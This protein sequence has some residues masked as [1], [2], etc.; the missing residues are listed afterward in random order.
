MDFS[1]F[2]VRYHR[3]L[4][5][6]VATLF[7]FSSL[8][9]SILFFNNILVNLNNLSIIDCVEYS[10]ILNFANFCGNLAIGV[11]YW[12]RL[13]RTNTYVGEKSLLFW[14]GRKQKINMFSTPRL[15]PNKLLQ[16]VRYN[17]Q[18]TQLVLISPY[19]K[20]FW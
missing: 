8:Y 9:H 4:N 11:K 13:D 1:I 18:Y 6:S 16:F 7:I 20:S 2:I 12:F 3:Q 19:V 17:T 14:A 10:S 5:N 15:V